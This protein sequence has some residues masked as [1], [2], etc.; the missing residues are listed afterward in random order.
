[1]TMGFRRSD[2][3]EAFFVPGDRAFRVPGF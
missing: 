2:P 3:Q 1:M